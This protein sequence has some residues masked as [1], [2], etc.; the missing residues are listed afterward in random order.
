[1]LPPGHQWPSVIYVRQL[2]NIIG[3]DQVRRS[4]ER[5]P[6]RLPTGNF[7]EIVEIL[8]FQCFSSTY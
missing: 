2:I 3:Q 7:S 8:M 4:V 6:L 5:S 1:M